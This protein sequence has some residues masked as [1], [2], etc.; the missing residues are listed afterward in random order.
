MITNSTRL[1]LVTGVAL[2][3]AGCKQ[4][5]TSATAA[6]PPTEAEAAAVVD[7][8]EASW[9]SG[10]AVK[11]MA[12]YKPGAVMFDMGVPASSTDRDTQMKWTES[13]VSMKPANLR[14]PDKHVQVLDLDTIVASG[15]STMDVATPDGVNPVTIRYTDVYEKQSDGTWFIVHEH[16]SAVP[17][18]PAEAAPQEM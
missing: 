10:D 11:I 6:A 7:A 5:G 17:P 15:N 16:L 13:F 2:A 14:V 18:A 8:A 12:Q 9:S 4:M 1:L 3:A